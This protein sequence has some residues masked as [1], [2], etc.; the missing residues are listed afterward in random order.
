MAE[1]VVYGNL[2]GSV[3]EGDNLIRSGDDVI[4]HL[5]S[6]TFPDADPDPVVCYRVVD[7]CILTSPIRTS[8]DDSGPENLAIHEIVADYGILNRRVE[9][10][11][12]PGVVPYDVGSDLKAV[13]AGIHTVV[14]LNV[15]AIEFDQVIFNYSTHLIVGAYTHMTVVVQPAVA[16]GI[17]VTVHLYAVIPCAENF[18]TIDDRP[19][20][21]ISIADSM[22]FRPND[23]CL[24]LFI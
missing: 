10:K 17:V 6:I 11:S 21:V 4:H 1:I 3:G 14:K 18:E 7:D 5:F 16:N 22:I 20:A 12:I 13:A 19:V 8:E 9:V 24:P 15:R 23:R 2:F